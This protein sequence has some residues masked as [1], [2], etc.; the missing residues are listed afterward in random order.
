[1]I[2]I[3]CGLTPQAGV[4]GIRGLALYKIVGG[5]IPDNG[6][7]GARYLKRCWHSDETSACILEVRLVAEIQLLLDPSVS[8]DRGIGSWRIA[9]RTYCGVCGLLSLTC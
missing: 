9:L 1:M 7:P 6:I 3:Q 4:N 5:H 2:I 8:E